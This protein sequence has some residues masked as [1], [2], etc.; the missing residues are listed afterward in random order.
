MQPLNKQI[1]QFISKAGSNV[2]IMLLN[3]NETIRDDVYGETKQKRYMPQ[4]LVPAFIYFDPS[5]EM[6]TESGMEKELTEVLVKIS[7]D[8][9][10][11]K[12]LI[13]RNGN[14]VI[15]QDD[16][17]IIN[18]VAY[19]IQTI[20]PAVHFREHLIFYIGCLRG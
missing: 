14:T 7:R 19:K 12:N 10:K 17:L 9:L 3:R 20:K 16:K 5:E 13:D 8:A 2:G 1:G 11:Q 6:L 18:T 4:I 15:T